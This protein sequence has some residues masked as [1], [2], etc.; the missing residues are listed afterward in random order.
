MKRGKNVA[1]TVANRQIAINFAYQYTIY[2]LIWPLRSECNKNS[3]E[4]NAFGRIK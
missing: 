1:N 4:K 3:A 2:L